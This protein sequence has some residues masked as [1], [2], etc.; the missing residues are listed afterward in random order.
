[1]FRPGAVHGVLGEN[2]AG[3][4]TLMRVAAGLC[5]P[6]AGRILIDDC[7]ILHGSPR[8]A[9]RAG[10]AMVHQ[11]FMLVPTLTMVEN[12]MIGRREAGGPWNPFFSRRSA[13]GRIRAIGERIGLEVDPFARVETLS[14]GQQQRVEIVRALS[15]AGRVL[16]LDEPTAVLTPQETEQL[17]AAIDRLRRE[18]MAIVFIS[19]KLDEVERICDELTILRRGRVVY[20]GPAGH[21]SQGQMA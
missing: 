8:K 9:M 12:C 11:H 1:T 21:L 4:T 10:I 14:V 3:K 5:M 16:I 17:F 19:H 13:A 2:G 20:A 7:E 18:G 6:D 15:Q